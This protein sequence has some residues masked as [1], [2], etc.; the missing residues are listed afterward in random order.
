MVITCPL[1]KT[2][3][4]RNWVDGKLRL[5]TSST[6][7]LSREH[8]LRRDIQVIPFH[9]SLNGQSYFD[10]LGESV[11]FDDFYKA[12]SAGAETKTYQINADEFVAY[13]TPFLESGRDIVHVCLST[14]LSGVYNQR[15]SHGIRLSK[16]SPSVQI[17]II[18]SLGASSGFGLLVD[19]LADLR[20]G[21]MGAAELAQWAKRA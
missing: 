20:D 14:G 16:N 21:G 11:S 9:F 19:K 18:D 1:L 7:D 4:R 10:D 5:S 3:I 15:I 12:M 17:Y 6:A 13:F 2:G 8:F